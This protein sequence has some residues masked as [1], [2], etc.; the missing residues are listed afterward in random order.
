MNKIIQIILCVYNNIK[1]IL[2]ECIT[3]PQRYQQTLKDECQLSP[4]KKKRW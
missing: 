2:R 4:R 1:D 3:C